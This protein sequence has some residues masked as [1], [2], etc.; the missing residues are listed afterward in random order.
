MDTYHECRQCSA[1]DG[2]TWYADD[3]YEL[4]KY[5]GH[6]RIHENAWFKRAACKGMDPDLFFPERGDLDAVRA[7]KQVCAGCPVTDE[8]LTYAL[9][10]VQRWG[11][12][13]GM[14]EKQ[15]RRVRTRVGVV[16]GN[17][18]VRR[19]LHCRASF[20]TTVRIKYFCSRSCYSGHYGG[21]HPARWKRPA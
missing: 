5:C 4:C 20:K 12:W 8:C 11:I 13:G 9:V 21:R 18:Y 6:K 7:A 3:G 19:C 14:S 10:T 1:P 2:Y 16:D 17:C 15:R